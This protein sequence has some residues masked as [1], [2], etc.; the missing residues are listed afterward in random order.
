MGSISDQ[1]MLG[2]SL[3]VCPIVNPGGKRLVYL[4]TGGDWYDWNTSKFILADSG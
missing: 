2:D 3:L 4:P 1:Y